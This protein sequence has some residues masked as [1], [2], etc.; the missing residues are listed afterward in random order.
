[1]IAQKTGLVNKITSKNT[2]KRQIRRR[3]PY[4]IVGKTGVSVKN[5]RKKPPKN[6]DKSAERR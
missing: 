1:M 4:P 6:L 2:K 3:K 5:I